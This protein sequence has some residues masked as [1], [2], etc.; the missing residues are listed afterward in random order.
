MLCWPAGRTP[1]QQIVAVLHD[2]VEDTEH[3]LGDLRARGF[4]DEI[5]EAVDCLTHRPGEEYLAYVKRAASNDLARRVKLADLADNMDLA[6]IPNVL[7]SDRERFERYQRA[8][9]LVRAVGR[10]RGDVVEHPEIVPLKSRIELRA[11]EH[12][13]PSPGRIYACDFYI[14]E[15][16]RGSAVPGGLELGRVVNIDHHA[17]LERMR[18]QITSTALA[19]E[20]LESGAR[21]EPGSYVVINHTDCDS[22]LS[23]A[24]LTHLVPLNQKLVDASVAADHTGEEN[25]IADLLQALDD[26]REGDRTVDQ[27]AQSLQN[28]RLLLEGKPAGPDAQAALAARM[29]KRKESE[30][31]VSSGRIRED[32]PVAFGLVDSEIDSAFYPALFPGSSLIVVACPYMPDPSKWIVK[33][34]L[35]SAAPLGMTLHSLGI[36]EFDPAFGGRWNA[37]STKRAGGTTVDPRRYLEEMQLRVAAFAP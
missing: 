12:D 15:A 29:T 27:Y 4:T 21:V 17:P 33:V 23:S 30:R 10:T 36:S 32:G 1:E 8:A 2:V 3:S 34:R 37:G 35:G 20:F 13:F 26:S 16:E 22:I 14:Q 25:A 31:A 5:I 11:L 7:Q 19:A 28:L 9:R 6:R 24:L 18:R